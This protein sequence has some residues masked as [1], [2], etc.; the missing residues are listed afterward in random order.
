MIRD[1]GVEKY[2]AFHGKLTSSANIPET[3][4]W[5]LMLPSAARKLAVGDACDAFKSNREKQRLAIERGKDPK[6]FQVKFRTKKDPVNQVKFEAKSLSVVGGD[7]GYYGT[8]KIVDTKGDR[9]LD[10]A[11]MVFR[12][13]RRNPSSKRHGAETNA[14]MIRRSADPILE[15]DK[16]GRFLL[17]IRLHEGPLETQERHPECNIVSLDPGVRTFQTTWSPDGTAYKI[18]DAAACRIYRLMLVGDRIHGILDRKTRR[19]GTRTSSA[20]R[21]RLRRSLVTLSHKIRNLTDELHWKTC[22][23]L[24][25]RYDRILIPP[26]ETARM[27]RK[28]DAARNRRRV[29]RKKTVRQMCRLRH[30]AFRQKLLYVAGRRGVVVDVVDEWGT[31]KTCTNCGW[32]H[33]RIGGNKV[34]HCGGCGVRCDRDACG[35]RTTFLKHMEI[36]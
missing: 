6:H 3:E 31:T 30:Y 16:L 20:E 12:V 24:T 21:R 23:F 9:Q 27:S 36:S 26:F 5:K 18:G 4:S 33:R 11:G 22:K 19:D 15:M 17:I 8:L 1:T 25:D 32:W 35:A 7:C 10:K 14:S 13:G 29:I 2:E 34:F 28:F